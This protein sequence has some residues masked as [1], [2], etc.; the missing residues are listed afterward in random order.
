MRKFLAVLPAAI[1]VLLSVGLWGCSEDSED[2]NPVGPPAEKCS[3]ELTSPMGGERFLPGAVD[4]QTVQIRWDKTGP[5]LTVDVDLYKGGD[6]V[7]NIVSDVANSGYYSW[8]ADNMGAEDGSDFSVEVTINHASGCLSSSEEFTL[9]NTIGCEVGF[10]M[11]PAQ[12]DSLHAGDVVSL[13]WESSNLPGLV[14]LELSASGQ[15]PM[16]IATDLPVEGTYDWTVD[17]FGLPTGERYTLVVRD[18][19]IPKY[20]FGETKR[21]KI[22]VPEPGPVPA[23]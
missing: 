12:N 3:I 5:E 16:T 6:Y 23:E 2:T 10:T 8:R 21:F 9:L 17:T 14:R 11:A 1:L 7:A 19:V 4:S 22:Q 15:A 13:A 20:C 18:T